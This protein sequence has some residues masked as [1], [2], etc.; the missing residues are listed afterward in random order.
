V[1]AG[2]F[3]GGEF[4]ADLAFG[5]GQVRSSDAKNPTFQHGLFAF[6]GTQ[7]RSKIY[8]QRIDGIRL[9]HPMCHAE[10]IV[11]VRGSILIGKAVAP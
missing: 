10:G 2:H 9:P 6:C 1:D 7:L 5:Q 11:L 3:G 4:A 8:A